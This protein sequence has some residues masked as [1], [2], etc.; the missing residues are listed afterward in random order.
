MKHRNARHHFPN[1]H[2][3]FSIVVKRLARQLWAEVGVGSGGCV[4]PKIFVTFSRNLSKL[5]CSK[6]IVAITQS[7][8]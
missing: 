8:N 7:I 5:W 6:T 4:K 1:K 2:A 3:I